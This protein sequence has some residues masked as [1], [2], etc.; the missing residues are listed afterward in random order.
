MR[1]MQAPYLPGQ[2]TSGNASESEA[3]ADGINRSH[4]GAS[5]VWQLDNAVNA[6]AVSTGWTAGA[7]KNSRDAKDSL[8][9][10][11]CAW[12]RHQSHL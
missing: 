4:V 6:K 7:T 11:F 1:C 2:I 9:S 3:T 10:S 5:M 12:E 8:V